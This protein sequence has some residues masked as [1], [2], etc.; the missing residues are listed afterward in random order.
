MP[1][2]VHFG[3]HLITFII[4]DRMRDSCQG[5]TPCSR[6]LLDKLMKQWSIPENLLDKPFLSPQEISE[7][8]GV[9][10]ASIYRLIDAR[11]LA[12]FKIGN[13]LRVLKEDMI[14]YL[15]SQRIDLVL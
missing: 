15:K 13:S 6:S 5:H 2:E 11:K 7:L 3:R 1:P 12:A 14:E 10:V 4:N 8:L 9:S